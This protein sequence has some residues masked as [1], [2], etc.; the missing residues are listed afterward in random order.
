MEFDE[1]ETWNSGY[2]GETDYLF[3]EI[4]IVLKIKQYEEEKRNA[5][6]AGTVLQD[7]FPGRGHRYSGRKTEKNR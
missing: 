4:G 2:L 7:I 5:G 6:S 3:D 1:K